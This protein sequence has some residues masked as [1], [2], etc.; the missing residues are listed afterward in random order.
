M[1]SRRVSVASSQPTTAGTTQFPGDDGGM[2]GAAAAV[3]DDGRCPLHYRFPVR[4]GHVG[5]QD[6]AFLDLVEVVDSRDQADFAGTNALANTAPFN[7]HIAA[8]F[9]GV[10]LQCAGVCCGFRRFPAAPG[11]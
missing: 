11:E 7:Q 8:L 4:I 10:A 5:N 2:A 3:G 9:Q 6:V 1:P